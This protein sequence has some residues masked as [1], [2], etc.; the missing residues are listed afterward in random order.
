MPRG[1]STKGHLAPLGCPEQ[2]QSS[3]C[4]VSSPGASCYYHPLC[5]LVL[6][7]VTATPGTHTPCGNLI[8]LVLSSKETAGGGRRVRDS[9]GVGNSSSQKGKWDQFRQGDSSSLHLL[10][11]LELLAGPLWVRAALSHLGLTVSSL[12]LPEL[13]CSCPKQHTGSHRCHLVL[14]PESTELAAL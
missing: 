4:G 11:D 2:V 3:C 12:Q 8:R 1:Q 6:P 10:C 9:S 14:Y 5:P 7:T 13:M